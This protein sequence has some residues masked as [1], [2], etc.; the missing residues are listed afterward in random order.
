MTC[1]C[2]PSSSSEVSAREMG[3]GLGISIATLGDVPAW[4]HLA[5]TV[6][7]LFGPMVDQGF[8]KAIVANIERRTAFCIRDDQANLRGGLLFDARSK[9]T[10]HITWLA[11]SPR[12]R[13]RGLGRNLAQ[14]AIAQ[15]TP[16]FRMEVVTF[17]D[18]N[19]EGIPARRLYESLGFV[20]DAM[21]PNGPEGG[22]RQRF[23]LDAQ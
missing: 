6:E 2:T 18:D 20:P 10:Y 22:S 19:P 12:S 15:A 4:L 7:H 17:G 21:Q 1:M 8:D 14:Y 9:P 13:G 3:R 23:V 11:V 5:A 16:P